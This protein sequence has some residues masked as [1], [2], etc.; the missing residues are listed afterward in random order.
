MQVGSGGD[1]FFNP[2]FD[3][4]DL[5]GSDQGT[6]GYLFQGGISGRHFR[7]FRSEAVGE[8]GYDGCGGEDALDG[9]ANLTGM[10]ECS[11]CEGG[12]GFSEVCGGVHDDGGGAAVLEGAAGAGC[13]LRAQHPADL[14]AA[15]EC[16]EG[17]AR[18][19]DGCGC[20]VSVFDGDGLAP[21]G[22]ESCLMEKLDE[23]ETGKGGVR[24]G[25]YNDRAA[26]GDGGKDLVDDEIHRVVERAICED[27]A[28]GFVGGEGEAAGGCGIQSHGNFLPVLGAEGLDAVV[29]SIDGTG[30]FCAGIDE[31][32]SP[33]AG[34]FEGEGFSAFF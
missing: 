26:G 28:D 25:F 2:F 15:D 24:C 33:F 31:W 9:N 19:G 22:W 8:F 1:G 29:D 7:G 23:T 20:E 11:F 12:G 5:L 27:G 30:N 13:E 16:E 4:I 14:P 3:P 10:V 34:G 21:P 6:D 18:V 17:D 32:F